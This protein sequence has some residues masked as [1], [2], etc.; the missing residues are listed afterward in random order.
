MESVKKWFESGQDYYEGVSIYRTLPKRNAVLVR[1]FLL[2]ENR[3]RKEKLVTELQKL[4]PSDFLFKGHEIRHASVPVKTSKQA[5]EIS[6][7]KSE[8]KKSVLFQQLPQELRP[9]LLRANELFRKNC[10][11]KS[12]L[13]DLPA[14]AEEHAFAI[15]SEIVSNF[16]ENAGCW[17]KIDYFLEHREL[18]APNE[19]GKFSKLTAPELVK[20]Q[21]YLFVTVSKKKKA[22]VENRQ[23]LKKTVSLHDF[24]RLTKLISKQ[25]RSLIGYEEDLLLISKLING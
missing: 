7:L 2:K 4:L 16:K 13:N 22:L 21:Q 19:V 8:K 1:M 6:V 12:E 20:R 9:V 3:L 14:E 23:K 5:V 25:E 18:P 17:K 10:Y 11:L 24:K 15:Q